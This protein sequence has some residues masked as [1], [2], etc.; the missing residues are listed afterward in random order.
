M[1]RITD[2][3]LRVGPLD[4]FEVKDQVVQSMEEYVEDERTPLKLREFGTAKVAPLKQLLYD[5]SYKPIT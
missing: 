5:T 1:D 3:E 2:L 4:A